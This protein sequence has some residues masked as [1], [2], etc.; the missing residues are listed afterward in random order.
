M[1]RE[2]RRAE[3]QLTKKEALRILEEGKYGV[4]STVSADGTPYGIPLNFSLRDEVIYFHSASEGHKLDNIAGNHSVS[5]CVVGEVELLPAE[6]STQ[7]ESAVVS[8]TAK[9][10]FGQEKQMALESLLEKYSPNY[11]A[12]GLSY[13]QEN[14]GKT[15]VFKIPIDRIT[16]KS[17]V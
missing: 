4:L 16:G 17:S 8:G 7:Y 14:L 3:K 11:Y 10:V 9:E 5:F 1:Q 12:E 13:I 2:M 6:F 15:S